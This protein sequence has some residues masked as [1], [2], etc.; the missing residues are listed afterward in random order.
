MCACVSSQG[1][2]YAAFSMQCILDISSTA[3]GKRESMRTI[4]SD[5]A[6]KEQLEVF[7]L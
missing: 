7:L 5:P 3:N 2:L 4:F 1:S 6:N